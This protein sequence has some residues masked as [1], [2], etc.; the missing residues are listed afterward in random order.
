MVK[1]RL[2]AALSEES[3]IGLLENAGFE[4]TEKL[5]Q[6]GSA[7]L[8][9]GAE[10]VVFMKKSEPVRCPSGTAQVFLAFAVVQADDVF[11]FCKE[12]PARGKDTCDVAGYSDQCDPVTDWQEQQDDRNNDPECHTD[13][14]QLLAVLAPTTWMNSRIR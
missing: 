9:R 1:R 3:L 7:G 8:Y 13:D 6:A 10:T 2:C 14:A 12:Q 11:C 5:V 4:V